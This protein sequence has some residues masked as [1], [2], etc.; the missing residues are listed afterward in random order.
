MSR[1]TDFITARLDELEKA[2][3]L[4][5]T[6]PDRRGLYR[7]R[8][9]GEGPYQAFELYAP[10]AAEFYVMRVLRAGEDGRPCDRHDGPATALL[11]LADS[12]FVLS[13]VGALRRVVALHDQWPVLAETPPVL[14][15]HDDVDPGQLTLRMSRQ[16]AWLTEREYVKRFG[17]EAPTAPMVSWIASIWRDHPD[18]PA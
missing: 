11:Q 10:D 6:E 9:Q 4:V 5:D 2:A 18:Y 13:L 16:I 14:E 7:R 12:G 17:A 3:T 8:L 15:T 1:V